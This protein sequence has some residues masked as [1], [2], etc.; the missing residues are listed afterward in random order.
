MSH[1]PVQELS[2][3]IDQDFWSWR[4]QIFFPILYP[5]RIEPADEKLPIEN[6]LDIP[7][8]IESDSIAAWETNGRW[9]RKETRY[10]LKMKQFENLKIN[11]R[12]QDNFQ[13]N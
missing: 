13:I 5:L 9:G 12:M 3:G 7:S 10:N 11:S 1:N 4:I 8:K 2:H 6:Q